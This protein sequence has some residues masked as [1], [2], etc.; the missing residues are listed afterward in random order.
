M[1]QAKI[2][3]EFISSNISIILGGIVLAF[4]IGYGLASK[5]IAGNLISSF[6][7]KDKFEVGDEIEVEGLSGEITAIEKSHLVLKTD[8]GEAI[9]PM[10]KVSKN[11]II[12]RKQD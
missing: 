3:T 5:D 9:V 2:N 6:Y 8:N 10:N 4:A 1:T 12:I 7:W 11:T